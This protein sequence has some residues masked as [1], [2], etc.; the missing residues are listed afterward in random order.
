[1]SELALHDAYVKDLNQLPY[2]EQ[3]IRGVNTGLV[4]NHL[5]HEQQVQRNP[6]APMI[7]Q[8]PRHEE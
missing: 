2:N 5:P 7:Y 6:H 3:P 8:I 1:M 4:L